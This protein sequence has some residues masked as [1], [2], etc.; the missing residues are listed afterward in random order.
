[1]LSVLGN[2]M[3]DGNSQR[4]SL[5]VVV[6]ID[7]DI[8]H[9]RRVLMSLEEYLDI[10]IID[11]RL[12]HQC[13]KISS[14]AYVKALCA[15]VNALIGGFSL[16]RK[17]KKGYGLSFDSFGNGI[18]S[19]WKSHLWAHQVAEEL[20]L[21]TN[22]VDVI[23][24]HDL[25]CGLIGAQLASLNGARL[26]YD[27]HEVEFHRNRKNSWLRLA[28][29]WAIEK[30]VIAGAHE[31][32]VVN[33]PIADLYRYIYPE[34]TD[35]LRVVLNNHFPVHPI[36]LENIPPSDYAKIIY[37]GGGVRG[38]QLEQLAVEVAD[39]SISVHAFFIG[40]TP[41]VA[42]EAGWAIGVEDYE[43][44]LV[45]LKTSHRCM[46]WCCVEHIS[47]SYRLSLPN[48][49]FQALAV[50]IPVIV[51]SGGYLEKL[52][53]RYEIGAVFHGN[54]FEQIVK[55]IESDQFQFWVMQV[56]AFREGL[57]KGHIHL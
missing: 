34:V 7:E 45:A 48:K 14:R 38:R 17:L 10:K 30:R 15:L 8:E 21:Q 51:S 29:D 32:R 42:L 3:L 18:K 55:Q 41:I 11:C 2:V 35:R 50:G 13:T 47:L 27:A 46:M 52:V 19:S 5:S 28:F 6:L 54:N 39:S 53:G 33:A 43:P 20:R 12:L 25:Y 40:K 57:R 44:D 56:K 37:V 26:V 31:V 4:N 16:W 1:M 23:H 24:A 36:H 9:D 49:F 22:G